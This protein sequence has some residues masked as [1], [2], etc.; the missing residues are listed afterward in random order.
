M[1]LNITLTHSACRLIDQLVDAGHL[2]ILES[3]V[4]IAHRRCLRKLCAALDND[5][6]L[7]EQLVS[8]FH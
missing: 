4:L 1:T 6:V 8:E 2:A 3:Q 5:D 7:K